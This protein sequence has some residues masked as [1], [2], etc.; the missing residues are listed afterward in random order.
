[1]F[2]KNGKKRFKQSNKSFRSFDITANIATAAA[3]KKLTNVRLTL[4]E[5]K[6]CLVVVKVL[7][8]GKIF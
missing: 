4:P 2:R 6:I 5:L 3:N 1:M 8:L 7:Y